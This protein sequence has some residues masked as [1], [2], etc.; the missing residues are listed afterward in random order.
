MLEYS[1]ANAKMVGTTNSMMEQ[2]LG[3]TGHLMDLFD[4]YADNENEAAVQIIGHY[5]E[6]IMVNEIGKDYIE[7]SNLDM[8]NEIRIPKEL[9]H[10]D[11]RPFVCKD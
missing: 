3:K 2:F 8:D 6:Q 11:L 4:E 10:F 5:N 7:L 1:D 9:A